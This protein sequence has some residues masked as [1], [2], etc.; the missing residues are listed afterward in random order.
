MDTGEGEEEEDEEEPQAKKS[1]LEGKEKENATLHEKL[2]TVA[3]NLKEIFESP[4]G[5]Y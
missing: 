1:R 5:S 2:L 3:Q 4:E